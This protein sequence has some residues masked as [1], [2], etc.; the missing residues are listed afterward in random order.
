MIANVGSAA[1][2]PVASDRMISERALAWSRSRLAIDV[3]AP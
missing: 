2:S 3:I 1:A